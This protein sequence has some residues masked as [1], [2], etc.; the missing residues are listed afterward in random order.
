MASQNQNLRQW[1]GRWDLFVKFET[2]HA[3]H[4]NS[5]QIA[6]ALSLA[7]FGKTKVQ[8][9]LQ[10]DLV[11]YVEMCIPSEVIQQMK[12]QVPEKF[13]APSGVSHL[14]QYQAG[15]AAYVDVRL[16]EIFGLT[17]SPTLMNGRVPLTFRLLGPNFRPVQ[18]TSDLANF[19]RSGYHEV[20]KELRARYPK[21]SWPED[22]LSAR[23]EAKGRKRLS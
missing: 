15:F 11:R 4:L 17:V 10:E 18:V 3:E 14:I 8:D 20:R 1:L 22:P 23:P 16:Q 19:W 9:V 7:A 6:R 13:T 2:E 21:H 5:E 12:L